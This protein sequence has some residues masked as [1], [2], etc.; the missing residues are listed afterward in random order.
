MMGSLDMITPAACTPQLRIWPSR[1]SAVWKIVRTS[2]SE[3]C[4]ARNSPP[5][6]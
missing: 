5:S 3:S 4:S 6:L 1:P 2:G